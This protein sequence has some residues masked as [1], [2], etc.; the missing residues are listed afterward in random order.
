LERDLSENRCPHSDEGRG[1]A[2]PDRALRW[3]EGTIMRVR[4]VMLLLLAA[5]AGAAADDAADGWAALV[6][7]GRVALVRHDQTAGGV[8]DPPGFRL[9]D[10]ATQR[11]LTEEGRGHAR[12]LGDAFRAHGVAVGKVIASQWCRTQETA[13]LMNLGPVEAAPTF[14]NAFALRRKV[15]ELTDGARAIVA[16]WNGP[17][18]LVVVTHGANIYALTGIQPPEGGMVVIKPDPASAA[19]FRVIGRIPPDS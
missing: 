1:H 4:F 11:N 17:G 3:A 12:T 2:F 7:G 18:A 16:R 15:D 9:E 6:A 13:R 14:N 10:C 5:G 8:G 19:K